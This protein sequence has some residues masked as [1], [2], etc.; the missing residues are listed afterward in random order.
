MLSVTHLEIM[1]YTDLYQAEALRLD[2]R[3]RR[4]ARAWLETQPDDFDLARHRASGQDAAALPEGLARF[5]PPDGWWQERER[6]HHSSEKITTVEQE[7][8]NDDKGE[9]WFIAAYQALRTYYG[10]LCLPPVEVLL[11]EFDDEPHIPSALGAWSDWIEKRVGFSPTVFFFPPDLP[12]YATVMN[13]RGSFDRWEW[14]DIALDIW[15][16]S[17]H[18]DVGDDSAMIDRLFKPLLAARA[19]VGFVGGVTAQIEV[20]YVLGEG[21]VRTGTLETLLEEVGQ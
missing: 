10:K 3:H 21:R 5:R 19:G 13:P 4:A 14:D 16:G 8:A 2:E 9:A 15:F 12:V 11:A 7:R 1:L 6:A 20:S 17:D 18:G